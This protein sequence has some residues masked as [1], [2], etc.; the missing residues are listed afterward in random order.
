[1]FLFQ[2]AHDF[3]KE[4]KVFRELYSWRPQKRLGAMYDLWDLK[5]DPNQAGRVAEEGIK[6]L[7]D[8]D[9]EVRGFAAHL[10]SQFPQDARVVEPLLVV[11]RNDKDAYVRGN[12][13]SSL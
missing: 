1:M 11:L 2:G 12:A 3:E 9:M 8:K 10:L 7:A 4:R 6:A 5:N 13:A